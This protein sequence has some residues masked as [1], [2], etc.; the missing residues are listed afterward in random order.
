MSNLGLQPTKIILVIKPNTTRRAYATFKKI[1]D[2]VMVTS[3]ILQFNTQ[4]GI[5]I[6]KYQ[7]INEMVGDLQRIK[8]YRDLGY[9][10][11][12]KIPPDV[13][14]AYKKLIALHYNKHLI[15]QKC[16]LTH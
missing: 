13:W 4:P 9:Q 2:N 5:Y 3:P 7:L 11:E 10:I 16:L 12:Q 6:T 14:L 1:W 15:K 8:L